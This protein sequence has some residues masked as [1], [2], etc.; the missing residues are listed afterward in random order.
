MKNQRI[1]Y[2]CNSIYDQL[3]LVMREILSKELINV[4]I[5]IPIGEDINKILNFL[6]DR[7]FKYTFNQQ[8]N[9]LPIIKITENI[10]ED[11]QKC[12]FYISYEKF[13]NKEDVLLKES[14]NN[15]QY[16]TFIYLEEKI[17]T[18]LYNNYKINNYG[19]DFISNLLNQE[20]KDNNT[21]KKNIS[22]GHL[23]NE[24]IR[25]KFLETFF[26]AKSEIDIISPWIS[27]NV[28]DKELLSLMEYALKNN[29]KIK[30][31][32][33]IGNDERSKQTDAMASQL[34]QHFCKYK[35][36]FTM[37]KTNIHYKLLICDDKYAISGSYNF[38]SFRGD[39]DGTD[40]RLEGAEYIDNKEIIINRRKYYFNF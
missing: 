23:V 20:I 25:S 6:D 34:L 33:G 30:I 26:I 5:N 35:E 1:F 36:L 40:N 15:Y 21:N 22:D 8:E 7:K 2:K 18:H 11:N 10:I 19:I 37:K 16:F 12:N 24:Q 39:Y 28:V 3:T 29:V 27:A 38:L 31:L 14:V 17:L 32:Y 13:K 9:R 4:V